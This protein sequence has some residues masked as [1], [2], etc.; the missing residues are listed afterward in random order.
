MNNIQ[1]WQDFNAKTIAD[2]IVDSR[3][4]LKWAQEEINE[5]RAE[6]GRVNA[7][8][9][10][11]QWLRST[12]NFVTSSKGEKIDV[13]NCPDEWDNAIDAAMKGDKQ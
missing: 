6:L 8:A 13:R 11:Y 9:K 12:T 1:R 4:C 2:E 10:R 5:L 3:Q 7:D